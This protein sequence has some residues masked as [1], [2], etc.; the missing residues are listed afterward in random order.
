MLPRKTVLKMFH[1]LSL[2]SRG[3]GGG[4]SHMKGTGMLVVSLRGVNF[5]FLVS[6][7]VF[8]AKCHYF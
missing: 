4:D 7:R 8:L 5:S 3:G 2:K 6:L 1:I